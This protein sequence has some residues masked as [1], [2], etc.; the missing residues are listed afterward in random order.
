MIEATSFVSSK[1]VP[2]VR[3]LIFSEEGM[4][5]FFIF[6][7]FLVYRSPEETLELVR[8]TYAFNMNILWSNFSMRK[9]CAGKCD[10]TS[11]LCW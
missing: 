3:S 2:Q 8:P 10:V 9:V 5:N 4:L 11:L 1:W 7:L 6:S